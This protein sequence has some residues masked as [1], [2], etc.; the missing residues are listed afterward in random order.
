MSGCVRYDGSTALPM[1]P[2][3]IA[4]TLDSSTVVGFEIFELDGEKVRTISPDTFSVGFHV[5]GVLSLDDDGHALKKG[6]YFYRQIYQEGKGSTSL[7]SLWLNGQTHPLSSYPNPFSSS[8]T[9][10]TFALQVSMVVEI[11]VFNVQGNSVREFPEMA[12][13]AG[14]HEIPFDS[15]DDHGQPLPDG[16]YFYRITSGKETLYTKKILLLR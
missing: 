1:P 15:N 14:A 5:I 4:C 2:S 9:N 13:Q 8:A 3:R 7:N 6:Y 10:F 12:L 16:M 11:E